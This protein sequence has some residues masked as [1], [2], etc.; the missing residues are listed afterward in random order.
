MC[1]GE[2]IRCFDVDTVGGGGEVA[3]VFNGIFSL[4]VRERV[5]G[6]FVNRIVSDRF[7][8]FAVCCRVLCAITG[9]TI[10]VC[11]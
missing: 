8:N 4:I 1:V 7:F 3:C 10:F 11:L 9:C 2:F 5:L 6:L